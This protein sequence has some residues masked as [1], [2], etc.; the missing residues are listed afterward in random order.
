MNEPSLQ[1]CPHCMMLVLP[2][3]ESCPSCKADLSKPK[4]G[5][6]LQDKQDFERADRVVSWIGRILGCVLLAFLAY[7]ISTGKK[8]SPRPYSPGIVNPTAEEIRT[9][10]EEFDRKKRES[11]T[12]I[13]PA[14][15]EKPKTPRLQTLKP[16]A[17]PRHIQSGLYFPRDLTSETA[18]L[19]NWSSLEPAAKKDGLSR[20]H[21][22]LGQIQKDLVADLKHNNLRQSQDLQ[23]IKDM[24]RH[25]DEGFSRQFMEKL[26]TNLAY[27]KDIRRHIRDLQTI[28][29]LLLQDEDVSRELS[30]LDLSLH[31][32]NLTRR[33][34][35][36]DPCFNSWA[37]VCV[38]EDIELDDCKFIWTV[39]LADNYS[40]SSQVIIEKLTM[41][42][43]NVR[44]ERGQRVLVVGQVDHRY[45]LIPTFATASRATQQN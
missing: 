40:S 43:E 14:V 3:T 1:E 12:P 34:K 7:G 27:K 30:E 16:N 9:W 41:P 24:L 33:V 31:E 11:V 15:T 6:T 25:Q 22:T 42:A 23:P 2:T 36:L 26:K 19:R 13:V 44:P 10:G 35:D 4:H 39:S 5:P 45:Q 20:V 32:I 38:V 18:T 29:D 37:R 28:T 21:S 8:P 17:P